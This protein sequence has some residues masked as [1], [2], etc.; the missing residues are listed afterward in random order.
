MSPRRSSTQPFKA[1]KLTLTL[2]A[3]FSPELDA[4]LAGLDAL[5]DN[6]TVLER[7]L[8][9]AVAD[10]LLVSWQQRFLANLPDAVNM[11]R[12]YVSRSS[13]SGAALDQARTALA[14]AAQELTQA[15]LEGR[16]V[17]TA[18]RKVTK[19]EKAVVRLLEVGGSGS[20]STGQFRV[21][22]MQVLRALSELAS[23]AGSDSASVGLGYLPT[24]EAI[25]T[26]SATPQLTGH[27]TT[28]NY[29]TLWKH[30][31]FGTGVYASSRTARSRTGWWYGPRPGFGVGLQGS[32][33]VHAVIDPLTGV[34]YMQDA[35]R[36]E[37]EV[38]VA[39]ARALGFK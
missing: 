15:Q 35:L 28:S 10:T 22:A 5:L 34:P 23:H 20:L 24:L 38:E 37:Q 1:L 14:A 8:R 12:T 19:A 25:E 9:Q 16:S 26:P 13:P 39:L 31:E 33:G 27:D 18:K 21:R 30:L 4:M 17:I 2:Q 32:K 6:P 7:L 29:T 36:F 3:K 11:E